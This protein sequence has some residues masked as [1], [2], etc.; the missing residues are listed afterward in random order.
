MKEVVCCSGA[1]HIARQI[2]KKLGAKYSELQVT[3]F[4]DGELDIKFK[5]NLKSKRVLLV[6]SFYGNLNEKIIETLF[7]VY[8]AK[9]LGAKK[10]ELFASHFPYF[11]KD[12]RFSNG[13]CVSIK[14]MSK[15]FK[16]FNRIYVID[17]HLHRIKKI[18]SVFKKGK[19]LSV[20]PLVAKY[21]KAHKIKNIIFIGPD[22]E[23]LQW[24]KKA[25]TIVDGEYT[26]FKKT[27]YGSRKVKIILPKK[28][29]I[30]NKNVIILDDIISSGHTMLETV[31]QIKKYKPH[32]I[33][34]IAI[35]GLFADEK[36]FKEL[37][38]HAVVL[39]TNTVPSKVAKI[40][41]SDIA[42]FVK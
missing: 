35:H 12:K 7:A 30:S 29:D 26:I 38:K 9:D 33:Y 19:K 4:P 24:A 3:K 31:R 23:S 13:E 22:S 39:S 21:L 37:K 1:K 40:D 2:A 34:C 28:V 5:T 36:T 27:R 20:V 41:I 16:V 32:K 17:P 15:L 25:A 8:T 42:K 10:V 18:K 14:V 6:Q 11:R